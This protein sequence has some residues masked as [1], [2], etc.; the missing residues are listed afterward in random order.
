MLRPADVDKAVS[1]PPPP[2]RAGQEPSPDATRV[3]HAATDLSGDVHQAGSWY[4]SRPLSAFA[5]KT[6]EQLMREGRTEDALAYLQSLQAGA[7][8]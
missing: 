2:E 7:V 3:I 1:I 5:S 8:G 6:A 4:K